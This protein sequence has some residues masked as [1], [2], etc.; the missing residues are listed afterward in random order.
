MYICLYVGSKLPRALCVGLLIEKDNAFIQNLCTAA[1][2]LTSSR[3]VYRVG[4]EASCFCTGTA[5]VVSIQ[6]L[7]NRTQ[8]ENLNLQ[9]VNTR[10]FSGTG[11][12]DITHIP[13]DYNDT[14]IQCIANFGD[15]NEPSNIL[16]LLVQ[17][18]LVTYYPIFTVP[19]CLADITCL[20]LLSVV[21]SPSLNL[22]GTDVSLSWTAPFTLDIPNNDPDI[23]YCVDIV[24][25][26]SS[27]VVLSEC[28]ITV[29]EFNFFIPIGGVCDNYTFTVTPVNV[30]GN[31]TIVTLGY[32]Q[33][34]TR[35]YFNYI[36]IWQVGGM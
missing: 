31:G 10:F 8:L 16:T 19:L 18:R 32:S 7:I 1:I 29:T 36:C 21:G 25:S 13:S 9:N 4:Y 2:T 17:G 23:T 34:F 26:T 35:M 6:W 14:T 20:G 15:R 11:R 27:S 24:N 12:L 5:S 28:G 22:A 30:V 3:P 33:D